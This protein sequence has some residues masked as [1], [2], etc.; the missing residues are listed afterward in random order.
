VEDLSSEWILPNDS[1]SLK[2]L[3]KLKKDDAKK[4]V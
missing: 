1:G 3:E 4:E 2:Q